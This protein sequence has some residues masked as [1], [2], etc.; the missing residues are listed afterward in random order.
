MK[1]YKNKFLVDTYTPY[2]NPY[3][4]NLIDIE[5]FTYDPVMPSASDSRIQSTDDNL[6]DYD[7][8]STKLS[9][10]LNMP[11]TLNINNH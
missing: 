6:I 1:P 7:T 3:N 11:N 9:K 10:S 8:L 4:I 5:H 2:V